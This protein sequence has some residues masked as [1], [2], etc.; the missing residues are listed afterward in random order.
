LEK[1]EEEI[2]KYNPTYED[3]SD[4]LMALKLLN[5]RR[6][7]RV[8]AGGLQIPLDTIW[9]E[10]IY[11]RPDLIERYINIQ[12]EKAIK[13]INFLSTIGVKLV[14]GGGDLANDKG[15]IYSPDVFRRFLLPG[16]KRVT[17]LCHRL[18]LF[19]LFGS[20]GNLWPI[21]KELFEDS[22]IDGYYEIDRRAGMDLK[23]L[24]SQF[25][26]LTLIGNISSHTLH[27]GGKYEVIKETLDCID[28]AREFGGIIV[29]CS[30]YIVPQTPIE[31]LLAMVE[32][33]RKY[34]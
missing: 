23:K 12:V 13:D 26:R 15:P 4:V 32:T 30:N 34:R 19:Y 18:G 10:A 16:I 17:E 28:T 33:I 25:P 1:K 14:F 8:A 24:R 2:E 29:G 11:L 3:F 9:L 7:L 22:G 5:N 20:D 21:S 27:T 6:A 31:N